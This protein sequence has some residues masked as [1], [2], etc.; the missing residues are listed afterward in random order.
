MTWPFENDTSAVEKKLASRSIKADKRRSIFVI[1]T[2]ALAVCLM[3]TLCFLYS[4]QQLKTLDG[5]LGQYQAGCGGLTREEVTRLVDA[6]KFEKWG[7]T[8]E[9][10]GR[11]PEG[12][13]FRGRHV[14]PGGWWFLFTS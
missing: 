1:L 9:A 2:I 14:G 12:G 11:P 8:V 13:G 7:C 3:G 4:A 5:I 6:G 10:G